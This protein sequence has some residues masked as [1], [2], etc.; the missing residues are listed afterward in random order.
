MSNLHYC[1]HDEKTTHLG[2]K[3]RLALGV[4]KVWEDKKNCVPKDRVFC[5][6]ATPECWYLG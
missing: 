1:Y 5:T 2:Y 6:A 4:G 3:P